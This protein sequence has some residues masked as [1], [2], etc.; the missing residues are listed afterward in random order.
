MAV[1][2]V[3][4]VQEAWNTAGQATLTLPG[5]SAA[6]HMAIVEASHADSSHAL[7]SGWISAY[8]GLWWKILTAADITA[9][10]VLVKSSLTAMVVLSG[11]A[12]FG[13]RSDSYTVNVHSAS[14][15]AFWRGWTDAYRSS[16]AAATYR[17]GTETTSPDDQHKHA[18]FLRIA[19]ATGYYALDGTSHSATF[20]GWEIVPPAAP[21]APVLLTPATGTQINRTISN[22]L[23]VAH[24][25]ASGLPQEKIRLVIRPAAGTWVSVKSDGTLHTDATTELVQSSGVVTIAANVLTNGTQ[26]E[27]GAYTMDSSGWSPAATTRTLVARTPPTVAVTLTATAEDL[28]PVVSWTTTPGTG[29]QTAYE[30]RIC[31]AADSTPDNPVAYTAGMVAGT[32]ADWTP[33]PSTAYVNGGSYKAWVRV[34]DGA[35]TGAWTAS[36]ADTVSWTAPTAP[37]GVTFQ[38]GAPPTVTV[39]G[40]AAGADTVEV[41]WTEEATG[42]WPTDGSL[43]ATVVPSGTSMVVPVPRAGYG[44][45]RQYRARITDVVD[46]VSLPSAWATIAVPVASTD[47]RAY[48]VAQG[49][50]A[51]YLPVAVHTDA[52]R[53]RL[54][55][56]TSSSGM[57]ADHMRVDYTPPAGWSGDTEFITETQAERVAFADWLQAHRCP[58]YF[59]WYPEW[60]GS[61]AVHVPA[62]LI[63][64]VTPDS[65]D[66]RIQHV[67]ATR[68]V[69]FAWVTQ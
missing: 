55:G 2:L 10:T 61:T 32:D 58:F 29:S 22:T 67:I 28:S 56:I 68:N 20:A 31:L 47:H 16:L 18:L 50:M 17:I 59:V 35:L 26:Y 24:Q 65:A 63:S 15:A 23:T 34:A 48:L 51:D 33:A 49:D 69:Q 45:S 9:A 3:G 53:L 66:R 5:G 37:S 27:W 38:Q 30:A 42:T 40:I 6:G 41:Q 39:A 8:P 25:S 7:P 60:E 46:T 13:R 43:I 64:R 4:S 62:V 19:T 14:G 52:R 21:L 12:G 11:A 36:A 44:V 54:E 57:G 1:A